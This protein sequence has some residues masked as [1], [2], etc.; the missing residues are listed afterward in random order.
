RWVII[1]ASVAC[2]GSLWWLGPR[3]RFTF[4]PLDD[5]SQFEIAIVAPEGSSLER[6]ARICAEIE[7]DVKSI[8]I[9]G[10]PTVTDTLVTIGPTS[11]RVGKAE[12]DVTQA[13]IY[14][15]LPE[16][17]GWWAQL[18]GKSR[19]WSQ[20]EVMNLT[21]GFLANY[22]DLRSSV[23]TVSPINAVGGRNAELSLNMMGPDLDKLNEYADRL[24]ER[25][26]R[27]VGLVDVDSTLSNRKPEIQVDIDRLKASQFGLDVQSIA[28]T[29]RALVGGIIVGTYRE[30]D[31]QYDVWLRSQ[32]RGRAT[33]EALETITL[34]T[35]ASERPGA[36]TNLTAR[37][38]L[39][40]LGNFVKLRE[41][42]GPNQIDRF[43]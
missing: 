19:K 34:R 31:D 33:R 11:G 2:V 40:Q 20:F 39:V 42:R 41:E 21:R 37:T 25:M 5:S 35:I 43:Q 28:D 36:T 27:D 24:M 30:N 17:E 22:P 32:R 13:T 8:R 14:C 3:T 1:A 6:V 15:R 38:D 23:Q 29:L 7:R 18:T 10:Q 9:H 26:R 4:L 12:G 16:L